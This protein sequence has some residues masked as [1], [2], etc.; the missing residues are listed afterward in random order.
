M[1]S[2]RTGWTSAYTALNRLFVPA[3]FREK[4]LDKRDVLLSEADV[5]AKHTVP[6]TDGIYGEGIE[7]AQAKLHG[8]VRGVRAS[9]GVH[10]TG[11]IDGVFGL[12]YSK[13]YTWMA[14]TNRDWE[15]VL[16]N[17]VLFPPYTHI[18]IRIRWQDPLHL[19]MCDGSQSDEAFF[20]TGTKTTSTPQQAVPARPFPA[21]DVRFTITDVKLFAEQIGFESKKMQSRMEM[22]E[23]TYNFD[24]MV[25][26]CSSINSGQ[27]TTKAMEKLP[28]ETNIVYVALAR[29]NQLYADPLGH[30]SSDCT[31]FTTPDAFQTIRFTVDGQAI[32]FDN[33]LY[34][35]KGS[36]SSD[37]HLYYQYLKSHNICTDEYERLYTNAA[38]VSYTSGV[39]C[40]DLTALQLKDVFEL[41]VEITW[42][43]DNSPTDYNL[44]IIAPK[45]VTI[46]KASK[47]ANWTSNAIVS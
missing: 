7:A 45:E 33:G 13:N 2:D 44:L 25:T 38:T 19:R 35:P 47:H 28:G 32:L 14:A 11:T 24:T 41:G 26:R 1:Y 4:I 43:A 18:G 15:D 12:S 5:D 40:L 16:L 17:N 42:G 21:K 6:G 10:L 20:L 8:G 34:T 29:S 27:R 46:K 31:R 30:R 37:S 39:Y 36:K 9:E 22:G 3:E 23:V